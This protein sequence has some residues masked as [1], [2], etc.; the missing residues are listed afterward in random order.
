MRRIALLMTLGIV[1]LAASAQDLTPAKP[2]GLKIDAGLSLSAGKVPDLKMA[3]P[4]PIAFA[5]SGAQKG[6]W[7]RDTDGTET[8]LSSSD[9][10]SPASYTGR[11]YFTRSIGDQH[12]IWSMKRDG[13]DERLDIAN[14]FYPQ[15]FAGVVAFI[16]KES[17]DK[18]KFWLMVKVGD[19]FK[20]VISAG[21]TD[22]GYYITRPVFE[23]GTSRIIAGIYRRMHKGESGHVTVCAYNFNGSADYFWDRASGGVFG[24]AAYKDGNGIHR[25]AVLAAEG[26]VD[27]WRLDGGAGTAIYKDGRDAESSLDATATGKLLIGT[28]YKLYIASKPDGSRIFA[29]DGH[30]GIWLD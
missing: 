25:L 11:I 26:S 16:R 3:L 12:D 13:S 17:G 19:D 22:G 29:A 28:E 5:R 30:D 20:K 4:Y 24:L 1:G 27:I 6:I 7:K 15:P 10:R 21:P 8:R 2:P 18:G 14:G 23:P 9:D